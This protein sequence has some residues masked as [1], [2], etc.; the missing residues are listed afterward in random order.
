VSAGARPWEAASLPVLGEPALAA[1]RR[2]LGRHVVEHRGRF[3]EMI[4][5]GFFQPVHLLARLDRAEATRPSPW[6]W[7]FRARLDPP[8][9]GAEASLPVHLLPDPGGY[10][11]SRLSR[12]RRQLL[13]KS[14]REVDLVALDAPDL[15]IDQGYGLVRQDSARK[16]AIRLPDAATFRRLVETSLTPR[17]ALVLAALRGSRLLGFSICRAVDGAADQWQIGVGDAGR[18]QHLGL[19][20]FHAFASVAARTPGI[21][22][23]MNGLHA[24]EDPGLDEFKAGQG[25]V[26]AHLPARAWLLPGAAAL[27]RRWD[28]HRF[29]RLTGETSSRR[30]QWAK[31]PLGLRVPQ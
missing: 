25:L 28:S 1:W 6:C 22:E 19:S 5:P 29:Y 30:P 4:A 23:V 26:V 9:A 16:A 8:A 20:L 2:A 12:K 21:V 3:W 24:R 31:I 7:G 18:A 13:R 27:L 17:R 15:L 10:E 11:I 14:L